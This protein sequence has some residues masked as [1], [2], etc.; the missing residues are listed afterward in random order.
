MNP[1]RDIA[2]HDF[3][4][5]DVKIADCSGREGSGLESRFR[6]SEFKS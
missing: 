5:A 2:W 1:R 6:T 4:V 3:W